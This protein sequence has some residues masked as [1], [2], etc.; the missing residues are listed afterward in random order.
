MEDFA[1]L[2]HRGLARGHVT[3]FL[4]GPGVN[5]PTLDRTPFCAIQPLDIDILLVLFPSFPKENHAAFHVSFMKRKTKFY[6]FI[7]VDFFFFNLKL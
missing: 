4:L 1:F 7:E 5:P 3:E 2:R 6:I